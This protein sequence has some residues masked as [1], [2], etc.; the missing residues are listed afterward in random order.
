MKS[1]TKNTIFNVIYKLISLVFPLITASYVS[2][3]LLS[4]GVGKVSY[5]QN[6][7]SYFIMLA[8]LGIPTYGVKAIAEVRGS[9]KDLETTFSSVFILNICLSFFSSILYLVLISF[10]PAFKNDYLLYLVC[11]IQVFFT[12][13]NTDWF[14]SGLEE[15][16]YIVT[17]SLIV[18]ILSVIALFITVKTKEDYVYYALITSIAM[19]GNYVFNIVNI[20]KYV[21]LTFRGLE[22]KKHMLSVIS[23]AIILILG[24][25]YNKIDITMLGFFADDSS[26]GYYSNAHKIID[27]IVTTCAAFTAAF[28]PRLAYYFKNE[29][30]NISSLLNNGVQALSFIV[31]PSMLGIFMV[32]P[33]ITNVLFGSAFSNS[34]L[35]IRIFVPVIFFRAFGD[36]FCYQLLI[37]SGNENKRLLAN[38]ISTILNVILNAVLIPLFSENGAAIA[39]VISEAFVNAYLFILI[40]KQISFKINLRPFFQSVITSVLMILGYIPSALINAGEI[41][42]LI[43]AVLGCG[44]MYLLSN[45]LLKNEMMFNILKKLKKRIE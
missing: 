24:T 25:L 36:L 44:I 9:K 21:K 18:K 10:V 33:L 37:A 42:K 43:I 17:R 45:V 40:K 39:S 31:L 15:Y 28:L 7:A 4:E 26:I 6:I 34:S 41:I 30:E 8:S 32:S 22:I 35:T 38:L 3:V 11:G 20:R 19:V 14:Y 2:R 5:A 13:I 23:L 12:C 1:L 29:K 16:T 27:I